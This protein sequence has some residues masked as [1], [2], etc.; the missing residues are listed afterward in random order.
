[1]LKHTNTYSKAELT[2]RQLSQ[3]QTHGQQYFLNI[4]PHKLGRSV[5]DPH[6]GRP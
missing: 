6:T 4:R 5:A 2:D 3:E 1:V